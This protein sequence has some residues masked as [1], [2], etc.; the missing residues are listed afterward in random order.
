MLWYLPLLP[1]EI[2]QQIM[3]AA[4]PFATQSAQCAH[5]IPTQSGA[6]LS[7]PQH[8][9]PAGAPA[10][11]HMFVGGGG[12]VGGG[13]G[14]V[15]VSGASAASSSIAGSVAASSSADA[16]ASGSTAIGELP[17]PASAVSSIE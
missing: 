14:G 1:G 11:G 2:A 5:A 15:A 9:A 3:P 6:V 7:A 17:P 16:V 13:P 10:V 4:Q 8:C 12:G